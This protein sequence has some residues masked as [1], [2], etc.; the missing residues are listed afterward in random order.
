MRTPACACAHPAVK[1]KKPALRPGR[2]SGCTHTHAVRTP[3]RRAARAPPTAAGRQRANETTERDI[4]HTGKNGNTPTQ[5]NAHRATHSA[6]QAT[7]RTSRL[8]AHA[9]AFKCSERNSQQPHSAV[10]S[11]RRNAECPT[12]S[13]RSPAANRHRVAQRRRIT[14]QLQAD[15]A[16][17]ARSDTQHDR[18]SYQ[19]QRGHVVCARGHDEEE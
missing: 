11:A 16:K 17:S 9:F 7:K 1:S 12:T 3:R 14:L 10:S 15:K 18:V 8:R 13:P 2:S 19:Q 6:R 5:L 4:V